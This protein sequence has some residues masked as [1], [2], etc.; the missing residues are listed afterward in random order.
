MNVVAKS[1]MKYTLVFAA[2]S[3]YLVVLA[4]HL[5]GLAWLL[6]WPALSFLLVAAAYAGLGPGVCGKRPDG[7]LACWAVLLLF[8]YLLLSWAVWHLQRLL[9]REAACNEVVPGL[10]VGRRPLAHELPPGT[11]LVVDLTAEFP[12]PRAVVVG[13]SYVCLPT[14]DALA[15]PVGPMR[16]LVQQ[17]AAWPGTVYIH[18]AVGHG[19]SALV[20]AAV[21]LARGLAA[22]PKE[23]QQLVRKARPGV[24]LNRPQR[25]LLELLVPER[26]ARGPGP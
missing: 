22:G 19:R 8:P 14:L 2:F 1:E 15:P 25:R 11:D 7:G 23:A 10:W 3:A 16:K 20:A 18:C 17:V 13:R 12:E 9:S 24:S 6:L 4:V 5:G 21:L 26:P